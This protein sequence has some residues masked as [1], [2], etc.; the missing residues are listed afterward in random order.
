M[1]KEPLRL[2]VAGASGRMGSRVAAL[3]WA[4]SRFH[5]VGR[6]GHKTPLASHGPPVVNAREFAAK[7]GHVDVIVDFSTAAASVLHAEIAA[8]ARKGIVI[9]TTGFKQAELAR[10]KAAARKTA[11]LL[12]PNFSPAVAVFFTLAKEAA[13]LLD[14]F[15]AGISEIHHNAKKDA[16]SGTA[17]K[18]AEAVQAGRRD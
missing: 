9:G 13:R 5:L 18:L 16:P 14:G 8:K 4:D 3:A 2:I 17:L 11:V 12:A 10:I 7:L 1:P 15:Q 6:L